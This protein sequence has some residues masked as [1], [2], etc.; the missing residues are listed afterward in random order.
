MLYRG[1]VL[2]H[3]LAVVAFFSN[4]V[5]AFF[6]KARADRAHD[7]AIVAHTFRTLNAGDRWIT[8]ISIA[9]LVAS[10]IAAA[11]MAGIPLLRTGWVLWSIVAF[12][13]S[14]AVFGVSVLPLQRRVAAWTTESASQAS[15]DWQRYASEARRWSRWAHLSLGLALLAMVLMVLRP[16]LP[17]L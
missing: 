16:A 7:A 6:W 12:A 17:A 11:G 2:V 15:F 10:G 14:G 9:I 5:G 8:P 1:L 3:L 13:G 4:A